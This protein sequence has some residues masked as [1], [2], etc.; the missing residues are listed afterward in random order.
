[1]GRPSLGKTFILQIQVRC[2]LSALLDNGDCSCMTRNARSADVVLVMVSRAPMPVHSAHDENAETP[3]PEDTKLRLPANA[4]DLEKELLLKMRH[5]WHVPET[6]LMIVFAVRLQTWLISFAWLASIP[7]AH[8]FSVGPVY[9]L[10]TLILVIFLNLGSRQQG[11]ASAYSIFN[12]FQELP[13][14]LNAGRLDDQLRR[15]QM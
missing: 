9:I 11:E 6:A 10:S 1:M 8:H 7:I 12:N 14:Q 3:E 13:G 15:G 4:S 2:W 5:D